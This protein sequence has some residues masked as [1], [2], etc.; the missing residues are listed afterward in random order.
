VSE[1]EI[2]ALVDDLG[3]ELE[4]AVTLVD[5]EERH[6]AHSAHNETAV[7]EV[8]RLGI[9]HRRLEPDVRA[10]FEQ[11]GYRESDGPVRTPADET[12][13]ILAR[14]CVPVRLRGFS[15]GY[16]WLI[17]SREMTE[18][19]LAP[20][21]ETGNQIA[22]LL[23]RYRLLRLV[24]TDLLRLVLVPPS[25]DERRPEDML[26]LGDYNHTGPVVVLVGAPEAGELG[27]IERSDL[28]LTLQRAAEQAF[29]GRVL[30]GMLWDVGVL[31]APLR[32]EHELGYARHLA[33]K[34]RR[35]AENINPK[36]KIAVGIGGATRIDRASHSY[37]EARRALR[38]VL[39]M[40]DL[41]P[42]AAWDD[43][44]AF[45]ALSLLP[46]GEAKTEVVDPRVLKLLEDDG[47]AGTAEAFLDLA[48]D[49]QKTAAQLFL[50]RTTLY[51]RLDRIAALYELDL[52]HSGEHRLITHLGL[53]FARLAS[54]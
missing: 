43:L 6:M 12:L 10:W 26:A 50:H 8:R 48:G 18:D 2:Q 21:V 11:W 19:E 39:A 34:V 23:Y 1:A 17:P 51:Q 28:T 25:G 7:D 32:R 35:L 45:R 52:R 29:P 22:A 20:A 14:W 42:I 38:M 41:G 3:A 53:K 24:D 9:L 31:L 44:G 13:G 54:D 47:L 5:I 40:P 15:L 30:A 49:V 4:A 27:A 37:A 33:V 16:L 46:P 36:L